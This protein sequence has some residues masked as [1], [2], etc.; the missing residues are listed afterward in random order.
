MLF[1]KP[2]DRREAPLGERYFDYEAFAR[3]AELAGDI[4]EFEYAGQ[5]YT[6]DYR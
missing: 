6:T 1:A 4:T 2:R 3:D 5:T